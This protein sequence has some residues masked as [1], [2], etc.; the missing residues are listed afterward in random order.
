MKT[1][2]YTFLIVL[3][4]CLFSCSNKTKIY[5]NITY[6]N[7]LLTQVDSL[8][9]TINNLV[10]AVEQGRDSTVVRNAFV[11]SRKAYKKIEWAVAY[12]LPHTSKSINGPALDQLDLD[13]NKY[14]PAEGYQ[15]VEEYLY[16]VYDLENY[17]ELL[18]DTKRLKNFVLSIRKNFEVITISEDVVLEALKME[19]FQITALGIT[20]FDTPASKLLFVEA[21]VSL[22]GVKQV[23]ELSKNWQNT[24]SYPEVKL[25]LDKAITICQK[26]PKKD[27][28]DYLDF[29]TSY[30]DPI[31]KG[32]VGIQRDLE[33][34]FKD[35]NQVVKGS[36]NSL[37]DKDLINLN[38]FLPDS[39]YYL[40]PA[41]VALGKELF[42][43][44]K[45]SKD[46]FRSCADCH[47]P[48]KAFSEPFK[49]ALDLK[50]QPLL[51]NTPSLNY[52]AYYHG[53]FWDMRSVTLESQSSD[54]ITNKDEMHG[55]LK[56]IVAHLNEEE[57]YK[58]Q[59]KT[60]YQTEKEIEVWQLENVLA[61]YIRSLS[62][63]NSRFDQ[64]MR[65][66]KQALTSRE[67][68]GFNLFVGKAQCATCHF[69]PVFNGTVPPFF[70]NSEQEV[71]GVP[72][73]KQ[74]K[75]LDG[76][77]GRYVFNTDLPQLKHS[78]KT[79]TVRNIGESGPYMHNGVYETLEEV[80]DFYN[81]GGGLGMGLEVESQTLPEDPLQLTESEISD[82]VLFMKALSD[83]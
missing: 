63:F 62:V 23:L 57:K 51:R 67:K 50:G 46:S 54:V 60:V 75:V 82:I 9:T 12:F 47:H 49:T 71:L 17:G 58:K 15:V 74:G 53:Q 8:E 55:D 56:Q 64:Y 30:L 31:A 26:N 38:A 13:E 3:V 48:D 7:Y 79:P 29:I 1:I 33:I 16:P 78:F 27:S 4:C 69:M 43:D 10:D 35:G 72:A 68:K 28:F 22:S 61:S 11:E 24:A 80:M 76:D 36:V 2:K 18:I 52:S 32:I 81:K 42:F 73:D 14:V 83:Q 66:N 65:G 39:T 40:T 45:L 59:F 21:A 44:K 6:N 19:L 25:L 77:L 70:V 34:P 5:E 41:K 37:F 20:G